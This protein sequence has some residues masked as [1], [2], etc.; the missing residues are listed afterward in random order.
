MIQLKTEKDIAEMRQGGRILAAALDD[1]VKNVKPGITTFELDLIAERRIRDAGCKPAFK[2]YRASAHD[3]PF[4]GTLCTSLNDEVVHGV[5]SKHVV[6][7]EGDVIGLDIG[8]IYSGGSREYILDMAKTV[9]VG[10]IPARVA[11]L[12]A[13]T[14]SALLAGIAAAMPGS[15]VHDI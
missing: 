5:P 1:V 2:G 3:T 12:L 7:K 14:Q 6:L 4:P 10:R 13:V 11:E 8:L 9:P 15:Y